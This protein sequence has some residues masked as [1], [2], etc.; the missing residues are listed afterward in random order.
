MGLVLLLPGSMTPEYI[1]GG[2][3]LKLLVRRGRDQQGL[4]FISSDAF[5]GIFQIKFNGSTAFID[6]RS[7]EKV[8]SGTLIVDSR[9][10]DLLGLEEDIEVTLDPVTDTIPVCNE[11]HLGVVS[12]KGLDNEKVAR[13]MSKRIDDFHEY[14]DDLILHEGQD[15]TIDELGINLRVISVDPKDSTTRATQISWENLSK[16]H[17]APMGTSPYNLC[18]LI[19]TGAAIQISDVKSPD[20]TITRHQ[21]IHNS[22]QTLERQLPIGLDV[23]FS[24]IAFSDDVV[25]FQTFDSETGD[26]TEVSSLHSPNLLRAY[27]EW[28]DEIA[29]QNENSPSNPGEALRQGLTIAKTLFDQNQRQTAVLLF[30]SGIYSSGQNP[31]KIARTESVS[32]N[33]VLFSISV[34]SDSVTD[35]MEA[36]AEEGGGAFIH[37]DREEK[38]DTIIDSIERRLFSKR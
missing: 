8:P 32:E 34:G 6:V 15:F 37:L 3:L 22:I 2:Y 33:V 18:I 1:D 27:T 38:I 20:G 25:F 28:A 26:K 21:A 9:I 14:L 29:S 16:I 19:E 17:L 30:S 35:I 13:A 31:V 12:I 11:I 5:S 24:G 36:I 7:S 4:C 10:S 23:L